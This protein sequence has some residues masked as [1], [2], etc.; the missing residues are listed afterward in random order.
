[1]PYVVDQATKVLAP[2]KHVI[3]VGAIQPTAF[4]AYPGKPGY[5]TAPG[6]EIHVLSRVEQDPA[7]AL[8][9]LGDKVPAIA[10]DE[11]PRLRLA[12]W[13]KSPSNPFFAKVLESQ[14]QWAS[15]TV[16]AKRFMSPPY[17]FAANYYWPEKPAAKP[18]AKPA[19]KAKTKSAAP[20]AAAPKPAEKKVEAP[21]AKTA[22]GNGV[23]VKNGSNPPRSDSPHWFFGDGMVHGVRLAD[24]KAEW[25]RNRWVQT[26]PFRDKVGFGEGSPGGEGN[27]SNVS[28]LDRKSTRLNSS[29]T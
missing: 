3:L 27:Q 5:L 28:A 8:A 6:A 13:M 7:Q 20:K 24:G 23:Y 18:T 26:Q 12:D 11:D 10:P 22:T 14:R 17:S 4:F 19:A 15:V 29:H 2:Y 25:Y 1:M 9:A 21:K 16:P